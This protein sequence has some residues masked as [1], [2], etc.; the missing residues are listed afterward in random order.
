ME[1]SECKLTHINKMDIKK[2]N[3]TILVLN[4][5]DN[6]PFC[7]KLERGYDRSVKQECLTMYVNGMGFRAIEWVKKVHN[8]T[9]MG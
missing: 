5:E 7:Y 8:T 9:V 3:R 2:A 4:A 1:C 6:L